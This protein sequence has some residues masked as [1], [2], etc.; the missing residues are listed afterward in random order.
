[1]VGKSG[2]QSNRRHLG[3]PPRSSVRRIDRRTSAWARVPGSAPPSEPTRHLAIPITGATLRLGLTAPRRPT[4][5]RPS[6]LNHYT[7]IVVG[8]G[9]AGC[10]VAAALSRAPGCH[11]LL[12]EAGPDYRDADLPAE[13]RDGTTPAIGSHDWGLV[14][15]SKNGAQRPIPRGKVVGGT[16]QVNSCIALR[17][18]PDDF[19]GGTG[20]GSWSE[21]LKAFLAV[22]TDHDF[23]GDWHGSRGPLPIRREALD[24]FTPVSRRFLDAALSRGFTEV[25]DHNAPSSTGVGPAPLNLAA[26]GTRVSSRRAFLEPAR[27]NADLEV[28]DRASV[29]GLVFDGTRATGVRYTRPPTTEIHV[30]TA[31]TIIL[32]AG[33]YGTPEILLRSGVGPQD[34]LDAAGIEV[35]ANRP[36]VGMNLSDHS[37]VPVTF[38]L[39]EGVV[40]EG[41]PCVQ[42]LLRYTSSLPHAA[43]NDMQL[44][45]INHVDLPGYRSDLAAAWRQ[46]TASALTSNLMLPNAR[47]TV[48]LG[49][50]R[51]LHIDYDFV[52]VDEDLARHREGVRLASELLASAPFAGRISHIDQ[53]DPDV[54]ADDEALDEWLLERLQPGHH[55]VGTARRG[56]ASDATAVVSESF[57]V[58]G[59]EGLFVADASILAEPLRANTNLTV[60]A[61]ALTAAPTLSNA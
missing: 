35:V 34:Q 28:L 22:E 36:G 42:A 27:D 14:A 7:H 6:P 16:S 2:E 45:M 56:P 55:P 30:A 49:P 18:D 4:T 25:E 1:M 48:T 31:P 29:R 52:D 23:T 44:C 40:R 32:V 53:P 24:D 47:G 39:D 61:L 11:V 20:P 60:T 10:A 37:Q 3:P 50:D 26:D 5:G 15:E 51:H 33:A 57:A 19:G 43:R 21:M 41:V 13:L 59:T 38:R 46:P 8:A 17:P 9:S 58:H 12:L 54:L